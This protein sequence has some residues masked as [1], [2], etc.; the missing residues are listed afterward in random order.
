MSFWKKYALRCI[1]RNSLR[2]KSQRS[3]VEVQGWLRRNAQDYSAWLN[4]FTGLSHNLEIRTAAPAIFHISQFQ[5]LAASIGGRR[6]QEDN[7]HSSFTITLFKLEGYVCFGF[8]HTLLWLWFVLI[9]IYRIKAAFGLIQTKSA[10]HSNQYQRATEYNQWR[11]EGKIDKMD[12][13]HWLESQTNIFFVCPDRIYDNMT[14]LL[15]AD[16]RYVKIWQSKLENGVAW[17]SSSEIMMIWLEN[18]VTWW[19]SDYHMQMR[20]SKS[21]SESNPPLTTFLQRTEYFSASDHLLK[22]GA[23]IIIHVKKNIFKA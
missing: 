6:G 18:M 13:L 20:W 1:R 22:Y 12:P 17:W 19:S 5:I 23:I 2:A 7:K 11:K 8:W 15:V 21:K 14:N 4:P 9:C 3:R 16:D 10:I